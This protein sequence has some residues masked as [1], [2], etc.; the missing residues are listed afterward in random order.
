MGHELLLLRWIKKQVGPREWLRTERGLWMESS[1]ARDHWVKAR[2]HAGL[3]DD[4][5]MYA[6]RHSSIVRGLCARLPVRLVAALHDTSVGMIEAHYSAYI[7]DATEDLVRPT[8]VP[9]APAEP[10]RLRPVAEVAA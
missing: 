4:I 8:L 9:L 10:A 6:F 7:V 1:T 2:A 3:P 5:V